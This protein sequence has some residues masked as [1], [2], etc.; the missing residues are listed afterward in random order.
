M[1]KKNFIFTNKKHSQ[2]AIMSTILGIIS[3]VSL[4]AVIYLTYLR[5]GNAEN[6]YGVT[7]LL[8]AIFSVAGLI[9]GIIALR[10]KDSYKLFP[11]LG[12][13][14]NLAALGGVSLILYLGVYLS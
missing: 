3:V 4:C 7:A 10:E 13:F 9:L 2:K 5:D 12:I 14:F 11:G 8:A 1:K 6:G